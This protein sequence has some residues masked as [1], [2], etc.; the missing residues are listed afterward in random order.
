VFAEFL[1][2]GV[3]ASANETFLVFDLSQHV[4]KAAHRI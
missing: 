2:E 4:D 3:E 1:E